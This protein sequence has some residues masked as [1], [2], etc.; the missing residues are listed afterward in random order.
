VSSSPSTR[1][2][3]TTARLHHR[4]PLPASPVSFSFITIIIAMHRFIT[5][6]TTMLH[7]HTFT[8]TV[9]IW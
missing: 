5:I 8:I 7:H 4:A 9:P 2:I 6:I 1:F 3:T